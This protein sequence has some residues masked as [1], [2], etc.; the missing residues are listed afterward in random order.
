MSKNIDSQL[1]VGSN[2][3]VEAAS[4]L[5]LHGSNI[6]ESDKQHIVTNI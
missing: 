2:E 4:L 6:E 5:T 1:T 3:D